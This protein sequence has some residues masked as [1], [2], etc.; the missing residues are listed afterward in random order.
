MGYQ[1][2]TTT[3][4]SQEIGV[5]VTTVLRWIRSGKL[6]AEKN[7]SNHWEIPAE[8]VDRIK[9]QIIEEEVGLEVAEAASRSLEMRWRRGLVERMTELLIAAQRYRMDMWEWRQEKDPT[10]QEEILKRVMRRSFPDL[11]DTAA[12]AKQW[13][14]F[15][16]LGTEMFREVEARTARNEE[17]P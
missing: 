5:H 10:Q 14:E 13:H 6:H 11:L 9:R 17:T 3:D 15:E 1:T 8:E 7:A 4:F 12:R 2:L 16:E